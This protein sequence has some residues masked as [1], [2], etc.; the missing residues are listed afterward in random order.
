M[1]YYP[2]FLTASHCIHGKICYDNVVCERTLHE[3]FC[4]MASVSVNETAVRVVLL[5]SCLIL[6]VL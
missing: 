5:S 3:R 6:R 2:V 1:D 4:F